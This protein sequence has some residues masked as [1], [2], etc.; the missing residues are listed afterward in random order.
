MNLVL[1]VDDDDSD[2]NVSDKWLGQN[3]CK[4]ISVLWLSN[5]R[6]SPRVRSA[7]PQLRHIALGWVYLVAILASFTSTKHHFVGRFLK[8]LAETIDCV[9]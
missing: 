2:D 4:K 9:E 7:Q 6:G 1:G 3:F 8:L 5:T